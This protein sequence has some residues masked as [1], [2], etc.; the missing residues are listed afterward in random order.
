MASILQRATLFSGV[1]CHLLVLLLL[2]SF[3]VGSLPPGACL[4]SGPGIDRCASRGETGR[5]SKA[6]PAGVLARSSNSLQSPTAASPSLR[7]PTVM[8]G[9]KIRLVLPH[10]RNYLASF[11]HRSCALSAVFLPTREHKQ[12][13]WTPEEGPC[14][15]ELLR[16]FL[17]QCSSMQGP[18]GIISLNSRLLYLM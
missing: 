15:C 5:S 1:N 7:I 10:A 12:Q 18:F 8:N 11:R 14:H 2:P 9:R 13:S 6:S 3:S 4:C 17:I 16:A